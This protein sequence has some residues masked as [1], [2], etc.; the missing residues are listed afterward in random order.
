[1]KIGTRG[2]EAVFEA[3]RKR[4]VNLGRD[5]GLVVWTSKTHPFAAYDIESMDGDG[6]R[7]YIEVKSTTADDPYEAFEISESELLIAVA[8]RSNYYIYRVT[9]AHTA[10]PVITRFQDPIGRLQESTAH[11]RLSGARLSFLHN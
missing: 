1:M 2:E 9:S 5:A 8:K 6:H 3:E 11:L 7:I 4:L 10:R